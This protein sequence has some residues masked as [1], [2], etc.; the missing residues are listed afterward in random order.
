M[1]DH[2]KQQTAQIQ[3][4]NTQVQ[5][6]KGEIQQMK[7]QQPDWSPACS[8]GPSQGARP[9]RVLDVGHNSEK[10]R[11]PAIF[12][13][14][15]TSRCQQFVGARGGCSKEVRPKVVFPALKR[16]LPLA[17][18]HHFLLRKKAEK[19]EKKKAVDGE[20]DR[21]KTTTTATSEL[22]LS[23]LCHFVRNSQSQL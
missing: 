3:L 9:I 17:H 12:D 13:V 10:N 23:H 16:R 5:L 15:N 4:L 1:A 20:E 7:H 11:L 14:H 2:Q 8:P 21:E 22:E 19:L 6:L 18:V